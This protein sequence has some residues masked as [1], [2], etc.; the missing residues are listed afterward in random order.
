MGIYFNDKLLHPKEDGNEIEERYFNEM[1]EINAMYEKNGTIILT[2]DVKRVSDSKNQSYRA[3]VPFALPSSVPVYLET[4]GAVSVRYSDAPPQRQGKNLVYPTYRNFMYERLILTKKNKDLAWFILKATNFIEGGDPGSKK[5]MRIYDP[6]KNI[7]DKASEVKRIAKVDALLMN[8]DSHVFN[9]EALRDIADKFGVD[10][11]EFGVEAAG[12][13]IR[14]AVIDADNKNNPE[15][16]IKKLLDYA[17]KI[18]TAQKKKKKEEEELIDNGEGVKDKYYSEE[19]LT[20]MVQ[21][22]L[23]IVSDKLETLKVPR[24]KKIE[25]IALILKAQVLKAQS[26]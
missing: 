9:I 17:D 12:F 14:E 15:F 26:M 25:Q 18:V 7:L 19:E 21:T 23:N 16:N 20:A 22:E 3:A 8:E 5:V 2:R 11:K 10:I 24:C 4:L 6:Q 13:V 1:K